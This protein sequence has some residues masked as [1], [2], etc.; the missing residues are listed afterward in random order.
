MTD[1]EKEINEKYK[2][3]VIVPVF[4]VEKYLRRCVDSIINQTYKNLEIILVDDGSDDGCPEICDRYKN[5]DDRI[6]VI[7]QKNGGLSKAR[8]SGLDIASGDIISL[9][10][11]DDYINR[12]MYEYMIRYFDSPEND[13]VM[14]DF[15]YAYEDGT[16]DRINNVN[17]E[18]DVSYISGIKAQY[19]IL[20]NYDTQVK[21]TVA[22]N[23]LYRKSLFEGIRYPNGRIYEDE[24]RTHRLLYKAKKIVYIKYPYYFY[25]QRKDS[26]VSSRIS[27]KNLQLIDAYSDKLNFYRK[28]RENTL[29]NLQARHAM[30]MACY[31]QKRL[32]DNKTKISLKNEIQGKRL[33]KEL[34]KAKKSRIDDLSLKIEIFLFAYFAGI[35]YKIWKMRKR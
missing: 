25:F 35:Y 34:L 24:A 19:K 11:S 3:S 13:I 5:I 6:I 14:C 1:F 16:D 21:Y 27:K 23:K 33:R 22:W 9:V 2:I 17:N 4:R 26:I 15:E 31:M 12:Y 18:A 7:H 28:N 32:D 29:W 10:D 8:N 20:K 30:H